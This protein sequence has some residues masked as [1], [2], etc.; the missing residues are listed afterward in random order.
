VHALNVVDLLA[1][2]MRLVGDAGEDLNTRVPALLG[3]LHHLADA[4]GVKRDEARADSDRHYRAEVAG[5]LRPLEGSG[6][7]AG[8]PVVSHHRLRVAGQRTERCFVGWARRRR[9]TTSL[10]IR[11]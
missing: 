7:A 6:M 2:Y 3:A 5:E 8:A 11:Y 9:C 1:D 10:R 4:V